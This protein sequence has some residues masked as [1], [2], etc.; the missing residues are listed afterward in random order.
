MTTTM[1]LS[2]F[3]CTSFLGGLGTLRTVLEAAQKHAEAEAIPITELLEARLSPDMFTFTQQIQAAT[4][5]TRRIT[6]RLS[7]LDASSMPDPEASVAALMERIDATIERVKSADTAKI[8]AMADVELSIDLG[9]GP[10]PFTGRSLALGF[11]VPNV[12]FH[13]ATAYD[14]MRHRGVALGKVMYI[15]PFMAAC[16]R[17]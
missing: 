2:D 6:D 17:A 5:T 13:A 10:M 8:D 15:M 3:V 12:L 16:G 1:T 14:I 9:A 7:G 4:D 11:A